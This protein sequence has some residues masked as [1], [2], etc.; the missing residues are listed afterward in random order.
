MIDDDEDDGDDDD[1]DDDDD[2]HDDEED[3]SSNNRGLCAGKGHTNCRQR[4]GCNLGTA[5]ADG[6]RAWEAA[7]RDLEGFKGSKG[8]KSFKGWKPGKRQA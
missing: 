8:F 2:E 3:D 5:K 7:A 4:A 6:Q 1:D